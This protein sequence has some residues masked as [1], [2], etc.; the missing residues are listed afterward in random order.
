MSRI[1]VRLPWRWGTCWLN[2][3]GHQST[4]GAGFRLD[5]G[6]HRPV[7][8]ETVVET[9]HNFSVEGWGR[10]QLHQNRRTFTNY[11]KVNWIQFTEDTESTFAQTTI[12]TNIPSVNRMF[13]S[14]ILMADKHNIPKGKMHSNCRLLPDHIVCKITQRNNMRRA[15][16]CDPALK[17]LNEEITA[18]ILKH[19][20]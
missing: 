11:K 4:S 8:V 5:G 15:N 6:Y 12:P 10:Q 17:L 7:C 3:G 14:I 20:L 16:A 19:K 18:D 2:G 9:F 13:T 1:C